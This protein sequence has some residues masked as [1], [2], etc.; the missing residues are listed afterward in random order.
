MTRGLRLVHTSDWHLGKT[1]FFRNLLEDQRHVLAQILKHCET[2]RPDALLIS[3]DLYDTPLATADAMRAFQD[4]ALELKGRCGVPM[5]LIPG[6]HDHPGRVTHLAPFLE[7]SGIHAAP[8]FDGTSAPLKP[9]RLP[10]LPDTEFYALPYLDPE[11][12]RAAL[13]GLE[14]PPKDHEAALAAVLK[15]LPPADP[16][17]R[18]IALAHAFVRGGTVSDSEEPLCFSGG[19]GDVP[20][21][22]FEPFAYTA[23]GHLHRPQSIGASGRLRYS[24]SPLAYSFDEGGQ[25]KSLTLAEFPE[26]PLGAPRITAL[27]LEPLRRMRRIRGTLES[28]LAAAAGEG[29]QARADYIQAVLEDATALRAPVERLRERYPNLLDVVPPRLDKGRVRGAAA[30]P[31]RRSLKE[32]FE[33]FHLQA[34]E[35]PLSAEERELVDLALADAAR[36]ADETQAER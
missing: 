21:A 13:S 7:S 32:L 34:L 35:R 5:V 36:P 17:V 6:N 16:K 3:G 19:L 23:L 10:A 24:G 20:E 9:L 31:Q 1:V 12:V 18:R 4:F 8:S 25:V 22:L 33:E 28:L 2:L 11:R 14:P 26:D 30:S 27:P 15:A 29:P